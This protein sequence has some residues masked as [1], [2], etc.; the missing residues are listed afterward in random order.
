MLKK[1]IIIYW[2]LVIIWLGIIFFLSS[3]EA[4]ESDNESKWLIDRI[5][6]TTI[7]ITNKIG[8]TNNDLTEVEK[9]HIIEKLNYPVRKIAHITEYFVLTSFM[10]VALKKTG[11]K[12]K[13][14][15]IIALLLCFLYAVGDE[16]HQTFVNQRT[17][18]IS[19]AIIDTFGGFLGCLIIY[20][21]DKKSIKKLK[22][23]DKVEIEVN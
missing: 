10:I 19:D 11:L 15:F 3:R 18:Q 1:S 8:I 14:V 20:I 12:G 17:G 13:K 22:K 7:K 21:I 23:E 6:K 16:Y 4:N 2:V 9:S 5:V